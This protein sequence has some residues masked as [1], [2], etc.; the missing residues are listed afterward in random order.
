[1]WYVEE[2]IASLPRDLL[3]E[4]G[5]QRAEQVGVVR[6]EGRVQESVVE[7]QH[8]ALEEPSLTDLLERRLTEAEQRRSGSSP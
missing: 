5:E 7:D 2:A 3:V 8:V 6:D 1:M 4:A